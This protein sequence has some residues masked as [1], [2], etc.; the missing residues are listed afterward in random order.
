MLR[1]PQAAITTKTAPKPPLAAQT[2]PQG[3]AAFLIPS[4]TQSVYCLVK[5]T[6]VEIS[7]YILSAEHADLENCEVKLVWRKNSEGVSWK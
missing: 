3:C 4:I 6:L 7:D 1:F 5:I 2:S